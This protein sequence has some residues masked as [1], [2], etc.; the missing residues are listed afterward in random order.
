MYLKA[1]YSLISKECI[2][3][4]IQNN[5]NLGKVIDC[6]LLHSGINDVY[7]VTTIAEYYILKIYKLDEKTINNLYL[8][9]D[10]LVALK[11]DKI[12][13]SPISNNL[14]QYILELNAVEGVRLAVLSSYIKGKE[15]NFK[16]KTSAFLYG[17]NMAKLHK[18]FDTNK[19]LDFNKSFD[20]HNNLINSIGNITYFLKNHSKY[21]D[22]F[23]NYSNKVLEKFS[24][25]SVQNFDYGICHNVLHGGN[26]LINNDNEFIYFDFDYCGYNFRIYELSVFKWSCILRREEKQWNNFIFGYES[27]KKLNKNELEYSYIF[28]AIRDIIIMSEYIRRTDRLGV[29]SIT[30]FYIENR[31]LFLKELNI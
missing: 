17:R 4:I 14:N 31:I 12:I 20:L 15:L 11:N 24:E 16:D 7:K 10:L 19:N 5:Y 9:V 8:E 13:S 30:D 29:L 23:L 22:I 18:S 25:I 26:V 2:I 6:I 3:E 21:Y 28:V 27:I 1:A